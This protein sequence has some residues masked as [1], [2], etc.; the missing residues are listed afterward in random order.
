MKT[1]N[2]LAVIIF[3]ILTFNSCKNYNGIEKSE[4]KQ[5]YLYVDYL[6]KNA[7]SL[8]F[9]FQDISKVHKSNSSD[10]WT[11]RFTSDLL[12]K[13]II[14]GKFQDGYDFEDDETH[15]VYDNQ[16]RKNFS[17][18][19]LIKIR[20]KYNQ[21]IIWFEFIKETN[22]SWKLHSF[23]FCNNYQEQ[24]MSPQLPCDKK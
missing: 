16:E 14:N 3:M 7:D 10:E 8:Y 18:L 24:K 21:D 9:V 19:H 20:S 13:N 15:Q 23:Y 5:N 4:L 17:F 12:K 6:I 2:I 11:L 1:I 22:S